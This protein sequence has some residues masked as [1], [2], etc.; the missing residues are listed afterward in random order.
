[1]KD[2]VPSP[3]RIRILG[4]E[5]WQASIAEGAGQDDED[6]PFVR[7][8]EVAVVGGGPSGL[9]AAY[10]L[11]NEDVVVLEAEAEVGGNA[12]TG[13][14]N[15]TPWP[16]GAIVTYE[17][18]PVMALYDEL[19]LTPTPTDS[20][21]GQQTFLGDRH[22][23]RPLWDGGL[24]KLFRPEIASEI[25]RAAG[26]LSKLRP[27]AR[28]GD[29]D[30]QPLSHLFETYRPE[31]GAFFDRLLAWFG[32]TT[33]SY[34]AY[35][36]TYL[37]RSQ[38]GEGLALLYPEE[39]SVGGPY[40]F[41]GGLGRATQE[42]AHSIEEAGTGRIWTRCPVYRVESK[43]GSVTIRAARE[44][45]AIAV[46]AEAA[47]IAV[48][49]PV[50]EEIVSPIPSAQRTAMKRFRY[51]PFLVLGLA[52]REEIAPEV[53]VARVLDG[54]FATF[55]RVTTEEDRILY[56]CEIP[57]NLEA[58]EH[59]LDAPAMRELAGDVVAYLEQLFPGAREKI[60]AIRV[61][62]RGLNWY[63]PVPNMVTGFQPR[64]RKSVRR[65]CFAHA[66]SLGPISEFGW[67]MVAAD[68]AADR[69]RRILSKRRSPSS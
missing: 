49:K 51:V 6:A 43:K 37:A 61:W 4:S 64:A 11:R 42:L 2:Q 5:R 53:P 32:G 60:E 50:A 3:G 57:F 34:S 30:R 12:R 66:D 28:R 31:V 41:P 27:E 21:Y 22:A 40:T 33:R 25:H 65:V 26:E 29:L 69:V 59:R 9:V 63:V 14:W 36:G 55:R 16:M 68:R 44:G 10:R 67:A 8:A 56:R 58:D 54:P 45:R 7:H 24:E 13:R 23:E 19:G 39:T 46:R 1:M 35:V 48:P 17:R 52:A 15:G 18:S 20:S 62:R 38:M 47:I